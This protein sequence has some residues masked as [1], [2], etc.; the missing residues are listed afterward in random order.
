MKL[1]ALAAALTL[2]VPIMAM[3]AFWLKRVRGYLLSLMILLTVVGAHG[4][5]NLV[6]RE[7]YSGPDRGFEFTAAD[8]VCWALIITMVARFPRGIE[9]FPRNSWLLL[10]FFLNAC[11]LA[12]TADEPLFTAF[13]LWKCLRI[14]FMYWGAVTCLRLGTHRRYVWLGYIG[15]A[16]ILTVLAFQQKYLLGIY[17]VNGPF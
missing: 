15:A 14:Y 1:A 11:L 9:W 16:S 8:L 13:S 3:A 4:S 7:L 2:A 6:S 10:L 5:I 17:R 12:V